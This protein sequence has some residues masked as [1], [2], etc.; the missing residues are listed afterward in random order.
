[1]IEGVSFPAIDHDPAAAA[2]L[3]EVWERWR[4]A[5]FV[6]IGT[7]TRTIDGITDPLTG[8]K[9][10]LYPV[11]YKL[12]GFLHWHGLDGRFASDIGNLALHGANRP[13]TGKQTG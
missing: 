13:E 1:M 7:W 9:I 12:A 6:S 10:N 4:N 3:V 5:S 8:V 11:R 2:D